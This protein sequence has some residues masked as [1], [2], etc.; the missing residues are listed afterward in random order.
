MTTSDDAREALL[1]AL[2]EGSDAAEAVNA[3]WKAVLLEIIDIASRGTVC[4]SDRTVIRRAQEAM[5]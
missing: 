2:R 1:N 3:V 5:R 4:V